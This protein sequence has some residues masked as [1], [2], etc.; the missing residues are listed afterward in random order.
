MRSAGC[1]LIHYGVESGVQSVVDSTN[2]RQTLTAV[3][4]GIAHAAA[5]GMRTLCYFLVG[6]PGETRANMDETLAFAKRVQPTYASFHVATPYPSTPYFEEARFEQ[7]FPEVFDGP[8]NGDELRGLARQFTV[9]YHLSFPYL[10]RR[11]LGLGKSGGLREAGL[12]LDY[13]RS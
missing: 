3:E 11:M 10:W 2:K 9:K 4:E 7:A 5:V 6:L 13:I 12:L 8:L 1:E